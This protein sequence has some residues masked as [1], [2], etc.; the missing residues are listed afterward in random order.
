MA[1]DRDAFNDLVRVEIGRLYGLAHLILRDSDRATDA[2]QEALVAAWRDLSALRDPDRFGAWLTRV[3]VRACRREARAARRRW[4]IE[5][6]DAFVPERRATDDL[7]AILDR[8]ELDRA[9]A[10]LAVEQRAIVVLHHLEGYSLPAIADLLAIPVGT[11]K[12]RLHRSLQIM[13]AGLDAD[14]RLVRIDPE[15]SA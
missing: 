1:G 7:P 9:F 2:T 6:G 14:A 13:R 11:V 4:I 3:L 12:S 5:V 15:R 10:R 8:D